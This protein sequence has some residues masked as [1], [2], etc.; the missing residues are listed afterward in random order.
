MDKHRQKSFHS[1]E[2]LAPMLELELSKPKPVA[3]FQLNSNFLSNVSIL[4]NSNYA[5]DTCQRTCS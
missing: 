2:F 1:S 4:L 3:L 5:D